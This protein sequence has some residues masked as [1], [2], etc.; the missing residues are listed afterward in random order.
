[1]LNKIK[2]LKNI[3]LKYLITIVV[4]F[5]LPFLILLLYGCNFLINDDFYMMLIAEGKYG[6]DSQYL[7]FI[8]IVVGYILK[9]LYCL[10]PSFNW[11]VLLQLVIIIICFW[12]ITFLIFKR[13]SWRYACIIKL[14]MLL[15]FEFSFYTEIQFNKTSGVACITGFILIYHAA[16][17]KKNNILNYIVGCI[18]LFLGGMYR[19]G[20]FK[21]TALFGMSLI[22]WDMLDV[23]F[24]CKGVGIKRLINKFWSAIVRIRGYILCFFGVSLIIVLLTFVNNRIYLNGKFKEYKNYRVNITAITDYHMPEWE[25]NQDEYLKN[26]ITE[27]EYIFV[28]NYLFA[29]TEV[30][31]N[32]KLKIM[33][34][35]GNNMEQSD[36]FLNDLKQ[37]ICDTFNSYNLKLY[38]IVV[39]M[40]GLTFVLMSENKSRIKIL[41]QMII[42]IGCILFYCLIGRTREY[43]EIVMALA[44]FVTI[45]EA[46][47]LNEKNDIYMFILTIFIAITGVKYNYVNY[48]D[49]KAL[50]NEN[51]YFSEM[52]SYMK[53]NDEN[54]YLLSTNSSTYEYCAFSL[55]WNCK[56]EYSE[57]RY[58]LGDWMVKTPF[59]EEVLKQYDIDNPI[60][61]LIDKDNVYLVCDD[62]VSGYNGNMRDA[63]RNYFEK[64]YGIDTK[65]EV[66]IE[67]GNLKVIK[68]MPVNG[69][70][71]HYNGE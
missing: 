23:L 53:K 57:N 65:C 26:G 29:D 63:F 33:A 30:F 1:M 64:E 21:Q 40:I 14:I 17:N 44:A 36:Y 50:C 52:Y 59:S 22:I 8:N 38:Y 7:I 6:N 35:M 39:L 48:E 54:F 27:E 61:S 28:K 46:S 69:R 25:S 60:K 18:L 66:V 2:S 19:E 32:D 47:Y 37:V 16:K 70:N 3:P 9:G 41:V 5:A 42:F 12:I 58:R 51:S 68:F 13:F 49:M 45:L 67:I 62:Y 15:C 56:S 43:I 20:V 71:S 34:D 11:Y 10:V 4:C 24:D 31:N 55:D